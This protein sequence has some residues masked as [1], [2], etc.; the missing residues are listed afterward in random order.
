[1]HNSPDNDT[2][3]LAAWNMD[4]HQSAPMPDGLEG[5]PQAGKVFYA[6]NCVACHGIDG[7]GDGPRSHFIR[8]LPRSFTQKKARSA[9]N[10]PG[11]FYGTKFGIEGKPMP[12]WGN[13]LD[14]QEIADIAEFMFREFIKPGQA[15]PLKDREPG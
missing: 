10:R 3:S 12:A 11:L 7:G 5:D 14:D 2:K 15:E 13:V 8:P 1:M 4:T 9:Y 6:K